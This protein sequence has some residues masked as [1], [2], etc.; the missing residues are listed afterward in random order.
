MLFSKLLLIAA[1]GALGALLRYLISGW[2][3]AA[4]G[5]TFPWGTLVAN[6]AGCFLIGFLWAVDQRFF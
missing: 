2:A 1:G 3:H 5:Q 4:L 6:L